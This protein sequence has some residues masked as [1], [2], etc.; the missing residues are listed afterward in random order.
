MNPIS[1]SSTATQAETSELLR[2]LSK[3]SSWRR[4]DAMSRHWDAG[5]GEI[6]VIAGYIGVYRV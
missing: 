6:W 1:S 4:A 2:F 5:L 3:T